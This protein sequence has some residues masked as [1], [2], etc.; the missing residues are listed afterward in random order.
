M[1]SIATQIKD[2]DREIRQLEKQKQNLLLWEQHEKSKQKVFAR[3]GTAFDYPLNNSIID[4]TYLSLVL[5]GRAIALATSLLY[6]LFT[7]PNPK[8]Q[9]DAFLHGKG[10]LT[11]KFQTNVNGLNME[12]VLEALAHEGNSP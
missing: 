9:V 6:D 12:L 8:K 7:D 3:M 2:I 11:F 5:H 4:R 1:T 10:E